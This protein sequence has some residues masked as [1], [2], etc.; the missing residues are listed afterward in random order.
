MQLV[1]GEVCLYT[2]RSRSE[3]MMKQIVSSC[4]TLASLAEHFGQTLS[5][6]SSNLARHAKSGAIIPYC[7]LAHFHNCSSDS[8]RGKE[9]LIRG[10]HNG[11]TTEERLPDA[12]A[13][14]CSRFRFLSKRPDACFHIIRSDAHVLGAPGG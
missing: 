14:V 6:Q 10:R 13:A 9:E 4:N 3:E 8:F 5:Q 11:E 2:S 12:G 7:T 1:Q